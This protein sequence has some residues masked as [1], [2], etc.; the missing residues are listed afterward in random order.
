MLH[1]VR[2]MRGNLTVAKRRERLSGEYLAAFDR[3]LDWAAMGNGGVSRPALAPRD[4]FEEFADS[5]S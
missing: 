1:G 5:A 3:A 4:R 2:T